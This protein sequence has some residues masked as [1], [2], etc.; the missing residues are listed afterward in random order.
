[1]ATSAPPEPTFDSY[2]PRWSWVQFGFAFGLAA[3]LSFLHVE[4]ESLAA[5]LVKTALVATS[6]AVFAGRFGDAAWETM[7]TVLFWF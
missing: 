4:F 5:Q 7:L 3:L 6:C 1:M 2:Q